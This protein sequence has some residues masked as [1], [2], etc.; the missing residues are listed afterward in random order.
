MWFGLSSY[1]VISFKQDLFAVYEDIGEPHIGIPRFPRG[2]EK[3]RKANTHPTPLPHLHGDGYEV[4]KDGRGK[5][6]GISLS[7]EGRIPKP[8]RRS[9]QSLGNLGFV[10]VTKRAN[11]E[12]ERAIP[13]DEFEGY[14]LPKLPQ[15]IETT[16]KSVAKSS[17]Y[18]KL[19]KATMEPLRDPWR[20]KHEPTVYQVLLLKVKGQVGTVITDMHG[21]LG[22]CSSRSAPCNRTFQSRDIQLP[23]IRTRTYIANQYITLQLL[24]HD[25]CCGK[26][27]VTFAWNKNPRRA[28]FR[29]AYFY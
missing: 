10:S 12:R 13:N 18:E 7:I 19:N 5:A 11:K 20:K 6:A 24:S 9:S 2:D 8:H 23:Q 28:K 27:N 4:L 3:L 22:R 26:N 15:S 17:F 1:L 14:E 21:F 25:D 16:L 29:H